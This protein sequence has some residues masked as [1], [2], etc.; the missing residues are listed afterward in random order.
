MLIATPPTHSV[1]CAL[2]AFP[3]ISSARL[4]SALSQRISP[5]PQ[6]PLLAVAS[7]AAHPLRTLAFLSLS[8]REVRVPHHD[9]SIRPDTAFKQ[10]RLKA[11]QPILTPK[12][13][14]PAFFIVGIIFAPI[15]GVLFCESE[16]VSEMT[17]DYSKCDDA[18]PTSQ[19]PP[20]DAFICSFP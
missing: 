20:A 8:D 5:L 13:V 19:D 6:H 11:W 18:S 1:S 15:G 12:T 17:I 14:L 4:R 10:Q 3:T 9:P 7:S 16:S 2:L